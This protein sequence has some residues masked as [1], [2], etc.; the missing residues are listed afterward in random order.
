MSIG[1][2]LKK[3]RPKDQPHGWV[4]TVGAGARKV[5]LLPLQAVVESQPSWAPPISM[6]LL[7]S[8][9]ADL[10]IRFHAHCLMG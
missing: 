8:P 2:A 1:V 5:R 10:P 3:C 4:E 6:D 7:S 9:E